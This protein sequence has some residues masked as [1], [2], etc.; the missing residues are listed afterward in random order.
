MTKCY[1][2]DSGSPVIPIGD[3]YILERWYA[4]D[5]P[6]IT[7]ELKPRSELIARG[8]TCLLLAAILVLTALVG[9]TT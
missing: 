3:A 4:H 1:T 5:E 7:V 8:L 9:M 2:H 6:W